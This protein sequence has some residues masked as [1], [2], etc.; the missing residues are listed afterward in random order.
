MDAPPNRF[1]IALVLIALVVP[2]GA[3]RTRVNDAKVPR[4][5]VQEVARRLDR[6][7][8]KALVLDVRDEQ[9]YRAGRLPTARLVS[10]PDVDPFEP[11]PAFLG[12][13]VIIVYGQ[14]PGSGPP[15]AL[16]KR[17]IQ[18]KHEDVH[19]MEEGFDAWT[20][21]GYPVETE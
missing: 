6:N 17:L 2:L 1:L 18:A 15:M 21:L 10:L 5:S 9:R 4:M 20:S 16:A 14:N 7:P 12:Y 8:D 11:T 3:C 13:G 19:L